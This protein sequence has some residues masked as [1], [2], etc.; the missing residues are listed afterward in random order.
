MPKKRVKKLSLDWEMEFDYD[1]FG[2]CSHYPDYRIVWGLNEKLGWQ[3]ERCSEAFV[4]NVT[5]AKSAS[6]HSFYEFHHEEDR[7][8]FYL[9][10]NKSENKL[11]M[12]EQPGMDYFL[13][14]HDPVGSDFQKVVQQL[15]S[16][17]GILAA[18]HFEEDKLPSLK[19]ISL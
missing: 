5:K 13:F 3:F 15:N 9:I 19:N 10:K 14:I 7:T 11:L 16:V 1:V 12:D 17:T 2:I 6:E 8:D 4:P 18:Y